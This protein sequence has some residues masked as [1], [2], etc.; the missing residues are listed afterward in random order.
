MVVLGNFEL[1]NS[2]SNFLVLKETVLLRRWKSEAWKF[3]FIERA[4]KGRII[5]VK[6]IFHGGNSTFI[7]LFD[8]NQ[9]FK[10]SFAE[11]YEAMTLAS[12]Q[13]SNSLHETGAGNKF[14]NLCLPRAS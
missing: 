10:W 4:D 6:E 14:L 5:T 13:R 2:L 3:G 7:N 12:I 1:R 8:K 11:Y 9:I